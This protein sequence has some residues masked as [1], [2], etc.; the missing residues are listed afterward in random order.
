M[1]DGMIIE[2]GTFIDLLAQRGLFY[3]L[4]QKH[5]VQNAPAQNEAGDCDV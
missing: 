1:Q 2:Q 5:L 3:S 4:W